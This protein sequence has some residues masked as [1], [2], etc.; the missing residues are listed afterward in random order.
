MKKIIG[1]DGCAL[2]VLGQGACFLG[3]RPERAND[4]KA[5]LSRG[6][7][8]GMNLVDTAEIYGDGGSERLI[9]DV[10]RGGAVR[11][12]DVLLMTKVCPGNAA[13]PAVYQSCDASLQRLGADYIDIYLLHWRDARVPLADTVCGMEELVRR[14]KILRWGVSNF[15]AGDMEELFAI[16]GGENCFLNQIL[17]HLGSRGAEYDLLPWLGKHNVAAVA[18]CPLA[19]GGKLRRTA[20][21]FFTDETLGA[22][23]KKY[24]ASVFQIMLAF[25]LRNGDI[26]AV[27]KA[28]SAA[29]V[30]ENAGAPALAAAITPAEWAVLDGVYL[31]PA[32]KMHLDMD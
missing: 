6:F 25:V 23:A 11:R 16:P 32:Y 22:L 24:G 13:P 15:D 8:L 7:S 18:Y 26:C 30:A 1:K 21:D 10:L 28:A 29:H 2:P 3:E 19:Q 20:P 27:P 4:E 14:G 31:P 5:A 12:A 9:G 17:Y